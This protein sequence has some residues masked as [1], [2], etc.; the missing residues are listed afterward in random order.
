MADVL[1]AIESNN[2]HRNASWNILLYGLRSD[3]PIVRRH[4]LGSVLLSAERFNSLANA[5]TARDIV[6]ALLC[7]AR[8]DQVSR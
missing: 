7:S 1:N 5:N 4:A 2:V 6:D 3:E 8:D